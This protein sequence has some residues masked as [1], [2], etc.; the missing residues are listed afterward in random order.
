MADD[1]KIIIGV[2]QS[3][4]LKAITNTESLQSKVKKLSSVY[5]KQNV[6]YK[7]Y[8][9]AIGDLAKATK[10]NK[11]ELL[12]YGTALRADE[13]ATK[14][15]T[16]KVKALSIARKQAAKEAKA[17]AAA[18]R[19]AVKATEDLARAEAKN[20]AS[21]K[22]MR[23]AT[24][25]VYRNQQKRLQMKKLL[26][27]AIVAETMTTEQAI[28]ALKKYNTAQ[29]SST[30]AMGM[31][32]NR[33]NGS[34]M[35]VQQLGYQFGDFA[36]QVQGGTSAFVAF[37]QQGAQLAGML[38]M[39]AGP[40]GLS[41]K[42]AVGLSAGLGIGIPIFSSVG[43]LLY[44]MASG[45]KASA[46]EMSLLTE[47]LDESSSS[48]EEYISL[49][50]DS[51]DLGKDGFSKVREGIIQ[52]SEAYR[53][54]IT[55]AKL[56]A[57]TDLSTSL[58]EISS[59]A[60]SAS[61]ELLGVSRTYKNSIGLVRSFFGGPSI[62]DGFKAFTD[63]LDTVSSF[64]IALHKLKSAEGLSS[65]YEAAKEL[66]AQFIGV[67]GSTED[68]T[69]SQQ[70]FFTALNTSILQME[71]LGA[72]AKAAKEDSPTL[73]TTQQDKALAS[74]KA[75]LEIQRLKNKVLATYNKYGEK[76]LATLADEVTLAGAIAA[77]KAEQKF[78]AGGITDEEQKQIDK[79]V[80]A[81]I[82]AEELKQKIDAGAN[83]AD[84]LADALSRAA[85]AMASLSNFGTGIEKSL[86]VAV[87]QTKALVAGASAAN[88]GRI[89]GMRFDAQA[90]YDE[91]KSS[92]LSG[93]ASVE[94]ESIFNKSM[95]GISDIETQLNTQAGI[96]ADNSASSGGGSKK[97]APK[98]PLT[99]LQA[100]IK[101]DQDLLGVS[102]A[103]ATVL[104]AIAKSERE[105]TPE[106][107]N[108]AVL[109]LEAYNKEKAALEEIDAQQKALAETIDSSMGNAFMSIIDGTM[110]VKDAFKSMAAEIIK[111]LY[112]VLVVQQMVAAAKAFFGFGGGGGG[113][114]SSPRP[115]VRP[116][117]DGGVF[118][119]VNAY[120]NGGIVSSP[121]N[122]P[123]AG[124]QVG[125]MGE[126][127]PE[128]IMPL[129]RGANGKLGVQMEGGGGGQSVVIN[130]SFNFQANGDDSVKK[131]I[132][133]AAPQIANMTKK[134]MLDD[135]RRGGQMKA[136]FG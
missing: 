133:Q 113:V 59:T 44:E 114:T 58:T 88:A 136:T 67:I 128:A 49:L 21:L 56:Q 116:Q 4:L 35:A 11:K 69:T 63:G 93:P 79:L 75:S 17:K 66:K 95:A 73:D 1:I 36:V 117:A 10:R 45:A 13:R 135:R 5:A 92:G 27:A 108:G 65:Q 62:E 37:S 100:R 41:M 22:S 115:P 2:E 48:L 8:N 54:L 6:T 14:R 101:L 131:L 29:M 125:L 74:S 86:A 43:R 76:T 132:A 84:L 94:A 85:S 91:A 9:K 122:F 119:K 23:M 55:L 7:H 15:A 97:T 31:A 30:K 32:K 19:V 104:R 87:A 82:E 26:K 50:E 72:A 34:N 129:K 118:T 60:A 134:S 130:Q 38:P 111:E 121:T 98:D 106:A 102:E 42:A 24:D 68:M 126:A 61:Y 20:A 124:N 25:S 47:A 89:A 77:I 71:L 28:V 103:R 33:M 46:S 96:K 99:D 12:D 109:K 123:M 53:E 39:I 120:A 81:A 52:T 110:S 80:L 105:Y 107:I 78:I 112:R 83:S 64:E 16:A 57:A 90:K 127:G 3:G 70:E 51:G 18:E 40:L